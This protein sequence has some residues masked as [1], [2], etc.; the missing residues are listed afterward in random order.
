M[1]KEFIENMLQAKRYEM[2]A[3]YSLLPDS[4]RDEIKTSGKELFRMLMK[5]G[6]ELMQEES[7]LNEEA[8]KKVRKVMID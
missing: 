8:G 6:M 2:K 5:C 3:M 1:K 4:V 7:G